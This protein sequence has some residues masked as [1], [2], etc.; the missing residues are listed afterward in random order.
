MCVTSHGVHKRPR[1]GEQEVGS[2]RPRCQDIHS[3]FL[4]SGVK[5]GFCG[6]PCLASARDF[7]GIGSLPR[8]SCRLT[9]V[10]IL[11]RC[12]AVA[13]SASFRHMIIAGRGSSPY[14]WT[15][16]YR[17]API[18]EVSPQALRTDRDGPVLVPVSRRIDVVFVDTG[19]SIP[20]GDVRGAETAVLAFLG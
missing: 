2:D 6:G 13:C 17:R 16:Q 4:A 19:R 10:L 18:H 8:I 1:N 15:T 3:G 11:Q 5:A 7:S 14:M 12:A 20:S 9:A